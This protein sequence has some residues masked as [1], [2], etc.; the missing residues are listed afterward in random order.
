MLGFSFEFAGCRSN[1]V[2]VFLS[3]E[4][5]S[6]CDVNFPLTRFAN[7]LHTLLASHPER[8]EL[9]VIC[10]CRSGARSG[11]VAEVLRRCGVEQSWSL[12]GGLALGDS[13]GPGTPD[14]EYPI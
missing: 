7:F 9:E 3:A 13:R 2:A 12:V 6:R 8:S 1:R 10:L 5:S 14:A 11:Q 4:V